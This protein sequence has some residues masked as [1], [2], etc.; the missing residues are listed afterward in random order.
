[1]PATLCIYEFDI[2]AQPRAA[3]LD[4]A[5]EDISDPKLTA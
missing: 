3:A 4:A 5:F 1:M 2:D